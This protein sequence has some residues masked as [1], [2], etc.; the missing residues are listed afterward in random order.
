MA[1]LDQNPQPQP[2]TWARFHLVSRWFWTILFLVAGL[3]HFLKPE[4]FKRFYPHY[5]PAADLAILLSGVL[6]WVLAIGLW[7]R[8]IERKVWLAISGLMVI[9]LPVH[10]YVITH[11]ELVSQ[12]PLEIPLSLAWGRFL[13]QF[14]FIYWT[15]RLARAARN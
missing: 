4:W 1:N 3:A 12:P 7:F 8:R 13:L 14:V 15:Y 6:E 11:H 9:Y 10:L 5:L 2:T